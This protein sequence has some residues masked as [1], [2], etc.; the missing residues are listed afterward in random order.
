M[1]GPAF[2]LYDLHVNVTGD[3]PHLSAGLFYLNV[4]TAGPALL[5][6]FNDTTLPRHMEHEPKEVFT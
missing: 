3:A 6:R 1:F 5:F 4:P 2:K